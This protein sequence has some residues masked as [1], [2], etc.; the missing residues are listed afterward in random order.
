MG[1][2]RRGVTL[3]YVDQCRG[4][5]EW[6]QCDS[7]A[8]SV[9]LK[10]QRG[11]LKRLDEAFK[12]FFRRAKRNKCKPGFPR[13]R[14]NGWWNSFGF[15]EF[16]GI[17]LNKGALRFNCMPGAL[18]VHLH[19]PMPENTPIRC[20]TFRRDAK[21]WKVGF[22]V[23]VPV[24]GSGH[25][26]RIVG[27]DLGISTFAAL[28]DG[29]FI[30]SLRA[31][32]RAQRRLRVAQRSLAR[33]QRRSKGRDKARLKVA[34]CHE[35]VAYAR[36]NFLHQASARLIRDYDVVVVEALNIQPLARSMLARDVHDAAWSKFISFLRYKAARAGTQLIEVNPRNSSQECS[37]CGV[38]VSKRLHDRWHQCRN[39]GLSID[40]DLNAARN[41]LRRAGV[42]PCLP[43]VADCGK[44]AG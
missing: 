29:G 34:R 12:G 1:A 39:C 16:K 25:G 35:S 43:N 18:R 10:L 13:F 37:G 40:R 17:S 31:A 27:V 42:G 3:G 28:S 5:T 19:R 8:A 41:I 30:P 4:L 36:S 9:P 44:R 6:R 32:R 22:A 23:E 11:T 21:G 2:Y 26:E 20:C 7:E 33:T 38:I 24:N 14:G 15:A